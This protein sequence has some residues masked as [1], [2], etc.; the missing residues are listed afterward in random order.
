[1]TARPETAAAVLALTKRFPNGV[2]ALDRVELEIERASITALIGNNGS[3]KTTLLRILSGVLNPDSGSV[4]LLG[5]DPATRDTSLRARLGYVSQA[6]AL[7]PEM[8]GRETLHLFATLYGTPSPTR[9][10]RTAAL[11]ESFGIAEHLPRLV[12]TY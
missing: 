6:A 9:S 12:S 2:V 10:A 8:T 7:D 11:G 5:R 4:Q 1:M 3:G